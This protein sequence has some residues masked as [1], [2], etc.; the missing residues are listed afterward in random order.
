MKRKR[1]IKAQKLH[2]DIF[3]EPADRLG[4]LFR[5]S[6]ITHRKALAMKYAILSLVFAL[7]SYNLISQNYGN[8][9]IQPN[10]TYIKIET[11]ERGVHRILAEDFQA[12][13][14]DFSGIPSFFSI[15]ITL[16][17]SNSQEIEKVIRSISL[18]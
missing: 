5:L 13:G 7:Y 14:F 16:I 9:W 1:I 2:L 12:A 8:D 15:L 11:T 6:I 4:I 3:F 10:Q 18:S 17:K